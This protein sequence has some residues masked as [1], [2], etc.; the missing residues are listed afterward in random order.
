[1]DS[2]K[3]SNFFYTTIGLVILLSG[4]IISQTNFFSKPISVS[5]VI[6]TQTPQI[7]AQSQSEQTI[8]ADNFDN[9]LDTNQ[10]QVITP[11][12]QNYASSSSLLSVDGTG[13]SLEMTVGATD[14]TKQTLT[15]IHQFTDGPKQGNVEIYFYDNG[16]SYS[17]GYIAI[18]NDSF[19]DDNA[20]TQMVAIGIYPKTY[21]NQYW[22][23]IGSNSTTNDI[24][25]HIPRTKGWHKAELVATPKG[26]YAKLDGINLTYLPVLSSQ[27]IPRNPLYTQMTGFTKIALV[28]AW[29]VHKNYFDN[30]RLTTLPSLPQSILDR[31]ITFMD[32][33][34]NQ[35][36]DFSSAAS[37]NRVRVDKALVL[38]ARD[39]FSEAAP[40]LDKVA[41]DSSW[42]RNSASPITGY[43]LGLAAWISWDSLTSTLKDQV[44][45][46]ILSEANYW[47]AKNPASGYI[48]DTRAESNAWTAGFLALASQMFLSEANAPQWEAKAKLFAYHT[49]TNQKTTYGGVTTQT[50]YSNYHLEN[51]DYDEHQNYVLTSIEGLFKGV[52]VYQKT[53]KEVPSEFNHNVLPVWNVLN[54]STP[55]FLDWT[56]GF[57][58]GNPLAKKFGGK[59]DWEDDMTSFNGGFAYASIIAND[60]SIIEKLTSLEF[61]VKDCNTIPYKTYPA[62][63]K[64]TV[65]IDPQVQSRSPFNKSLYAGEYLMN[66]V[67]AERH[68][69]SYLLL[70][71]DLKL[72]P[73]NQMVTPNPTSSPTSPVELSPTPTSTSS[74]TPTATPSS[75]PTST[76]PIFQESFE[77]NLS[78]WNIIN[79]DSV[80]N[81]ISISA[82]NPL[83]GNNL[84]ITLNNPAQAVTLI[85]Q[86][87]TSQSGKTE[88]N[89]YDDYPNNNGTYVAITNNSYPD[90]RDNTQM[91]AVGIY[92]N[93]F[94]QTYWY[95]PGVNSSSLNINTKVTRTK[96]WHKVEFYTTTSGSYAVLDGV[97]LSKLSGGKF[98][99]MTS[100]TKIAL[101]SAWTPIHFSLFDEIKVFP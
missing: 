16:N 28:S 41:N 74:P 77:S 58:T 85:H 92:P 86:F 37:P 43:G 78:E 31:E 12:T 83:S 29:S 70:N 54:G 1:M 56:T 11:V 95:R 20:N 4:I 30:L 10:W 71:S 3:Q 13:K 33:F 96:G 73:I 84:N 101:V 22:Y 68:A 15:L 60:P 49:F 50:L 69:Y 63:T 26:S 65:W 99:S 45:Q 27:K 21:S 75:T 17:G 8:F 64:Q 53:G 46:V 61:Y 76:S 5:S 82:S 59:D 91:I 38:G 14:K 42:Q 47:V 39:R 62:I 6:K 81:G 97:D 18:T 98:N 67:S 24:N 93:A 40:Y 52:L 34:L 79:L 89:F 9:G 19:P 35:P 25:T 90:D 72:K 57:L 94:S 51:H 36:E 2:N 32:I 80:N 66:A 7:L 100:F 87:S 88:I 44:K 48:S 23:R 55:A